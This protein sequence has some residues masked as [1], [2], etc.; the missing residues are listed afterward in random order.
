MYPRLFPFSNE[1]WRN[2]DFSEEQIKYLFIDGVNFNMRIG[3][4]IERTPVLTAIGVAESGQRLV[5][6]LQVGDKESASAWREF[7][8]DLKRRGLDSS[9]VVLGVMDGLPGL[10]KVFAEE[11]PKAKI[12]RCQVHVARNV[13]AKVPQ[14]FKEAIADGMRSI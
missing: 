7:F 13:L 4:S 5:L 6:G 1:G 14:K 8:K 2:R 11:F 3:D 10:E 9:K 12:Q